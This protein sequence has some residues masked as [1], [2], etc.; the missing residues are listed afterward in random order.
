VTITSLSLQGD[1][2]DYGDD[3]VDPVILSQDLLSGLVFTP[4]GAQETALAHGPLHVQVK[5]DRLTVN[6]ASIRTV[7]D[8]IRRR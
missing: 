2:N 3:V 6:A 8:T 5:D 4:G 7:A 1:L